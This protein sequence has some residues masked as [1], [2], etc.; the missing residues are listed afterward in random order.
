[1]LEL[2]ASNVR[3][4][5]TAP[6]KWIASPSRWDSLLSWAEYLDLILKA[7][8]V[9]SEFSEADPFL[10]SVDS[11]AFAGKVAVKSSISAI[12]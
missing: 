5:Y 4:I 8:W 6:S 10:L 1:M 11:A 9:V 12:A 3:S 2:A 7:R